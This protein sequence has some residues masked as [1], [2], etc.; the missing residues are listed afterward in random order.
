MSKHTETPWKASMPQGSNGYWV[1][2]KLGVELASCWSISIDEDAEDNANFIIKAV[3]SHDQLV[4]ALKIYGNHQQSCATMSHFRE[5]GYE[6]TCGYE[7]ALKAAGEE[8]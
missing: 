6:C 3:N 2:E 5:E 8:S 7:E 4:G 1:I